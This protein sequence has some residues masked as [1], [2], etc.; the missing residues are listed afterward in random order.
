MTS[1]EYSIEY[2]KQGIY[3]LIGHNPLNKTNIVLAKADSPSKLLEYG[4]LD[5][6]ITQQIVMSGAVN[7]IMDLE[8]MQ[9][10][11]GINAHNEMMDIIQKLIDGLL[12]KK[13]DE[14]NYYE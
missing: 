9:T 2:L 13:L 12:D 6:N 1:T 10:M 4:Y 7:A 14:E 3:V 5:L 8:T 11:G